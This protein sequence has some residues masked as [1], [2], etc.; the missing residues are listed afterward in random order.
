MENVYG[1]VDRFYKDDISSCVVI[2]QE[3]TERYLR[4]LA[5][6][7][8]NDSELTQIWSVLRNLLLYADHMKLFKLDL[9]MVTDYQ[10]I[11]HEHVYDSEEST[12]YQ[13]YVAKFFKILGNFYA[14]NSELVSR[15][16]LA[17]FNKAKASFY[18][19]G[20]FAPPNIELHGE[21]RPSG[22]EIAEVGNTFIEEMDKKMEKL[23]VRVQEYFRGPKYAEDTERA[24][25]LFSCPMDT[26][27][28]R[29]DTVFWNEFWDYFFF[30]YHLLSNDK[31]PVQQYIED[32]GAE[33]SAQDRFSL[34]WF[35]RTPYNVLVVEEMTYDSLVCRDLF[36]DEEVEFMGSYSF[37]VDP[38]KML[39]CGHRHRGLEDYELGCMSCIP[40]A[41]AQQKRIKEDVLHQFEAFKAQEPTATMEDYLARHA[42]AVRQNI[43]LISQGLLLRVPGY[44]FAQPQCVNEEQMPPN[45]LV[46]RFNG[47]M[48]KFGV[49]CHGCMLAARLYS[50]AYR[51]ARSVDADYSDDEIMNAS[52]LL[53]LLTNDMEENDS[54]L[55]EELNLDYSRMPNLVN[56]LADGI[57]WQYYDPRYLSE[58]GF[59]NSL[60]ALQY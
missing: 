33:I 5:W 42:G 34:K 9:F 24:L 7:G 35:M 55:F 4:R 57:D 3:T 22:E 20:E 39:L 58:E 51:Y 54:E 36:T 44:D 47:K 49:S 41:P 17:V 6:K 56:L 16:A 52:L 13:D 30:N 19:D 2:T 60:Y 45:D 26:V 27:E 12:S 40:A 10:D 31:L 53:Y 43:E 37:P 8:H 23:L 11:I 32:M 14:L 1:K 28:K 46:E 38:F 25:K 18:E 50:D 21:F 15:P 59:V 48:R 29:D